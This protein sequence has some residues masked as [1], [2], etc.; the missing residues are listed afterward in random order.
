MS[1]L[2]IV[3]LGLLVLGIALY[4]SLRKKTSRKPVEPEELKQSLEPE[5]DEVTEVGETKPT[6]ILEEAIHLALE[7]GKLSKGEE[8]MLRKKAMLVGKDPDI[9]I[10]QLREDLF[11]L[12]E[13]ECKEVDP[14]FN[15][16]LI[17]EK[18]VVQK[19]NPQFFSSGS[20]GRR[21]VY[22]RSLYQYSSQ[23][24]YSGDDQYRSR[25]FSSGYRM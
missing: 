4:I 14:D 23:S 15:P 16:G 24:R 17:F 25:Q 5:K 21:K 8:V 11:G 2:F 18:Y 10:Q 9:L 6:Y 1:Q 13:D 7:D 22:C 3:L 20:L 19:F 12:E